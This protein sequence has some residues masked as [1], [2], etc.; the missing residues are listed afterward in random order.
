MTSPNPYD[1][2]AAIA[3]RLQAA[4][5]PFRATVLAVSGAE[6]E[7][8][9][10][11]GP[12]SLGLSP[13]S[14]YVAARAQVGDRVICMYVDGIAFVVAFEATATPAARTLFIPAPAFIAADGSPALTARGSSANGVEDS[15]GWALD[16]GTAESV[17]ALAQLPVDYDDG[18]V[19]ITVYLAPSG[20]G[21]GNVVIE[22]YGAALTAGTQIDQAAAFSDGDA[23]AMPGVADQLTTITFAAAGTALS[24]DALRLAVRR[25]ATDGSDTYAADVWLLGVRIDYRTRDV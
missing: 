13:A 7:V 1:A 21:S 24:G 20:S 16:A 15:P 12:G 22:I 8:E 3:R 14:P 11:G 6:I 2:A 4:T 10:D 5:A 23:L 19:D 9:P 18:D 17:V 25:D